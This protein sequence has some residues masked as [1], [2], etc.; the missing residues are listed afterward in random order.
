VLCDDLIE[1]IKN[2]D[3]AEAQIR[4]LPRNDID[5]LIQGIAN[6]KYELDK[7]EKSDSD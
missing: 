2:R 1:E 3:A 7:L 4:A 6:V 5:E